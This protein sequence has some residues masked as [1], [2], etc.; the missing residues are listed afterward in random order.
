[1]AEGSGGSDPDKDCGAGELESDPGSG[2]LN[3]RE[4]LLNKDMCNS[5]DDE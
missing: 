5:F 2:D 3:P 1:M 4:S